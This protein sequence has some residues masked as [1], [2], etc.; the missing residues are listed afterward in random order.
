MK[1]MK[2]MFAVACLLTVVGSA[3]AQNAETKRNFGYVDSKTG[4]FHPLNR[5]P[6]SDEILATITPTSGKFVFNVTITVSSALPTTAVISC[7]VNGF[8]DD[9]LTGDFSNFVEVT[10]KR[11]GNTATCTLTVPYEWYLGQPT[12]DIVEMDLTVDATAGITGTTGF[13]EETFSTPAITMAVPVTGTTTTK[14]IT[15]TI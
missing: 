6:L 7:G 8:V 2:W 11:T 12:K 3:F 4:M 1:S 15:T 14:T 10:A 5:T 9:L 13:Y